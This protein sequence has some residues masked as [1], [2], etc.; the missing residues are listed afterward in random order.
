MGT[1]RTI[2]GVFADEKRAL[3]A[4]SALKETAWSVRRVHSPIPSR[5]IAEALSVKPSRVGIFTLIGGIIGFFTGFALAAYTALQWNL[6]IS[7]KPV[8]ALVPFF[9]V[10]FEFTILFAVFGNVVGLIYQMKLPDYRGL[11]HHDSRTTG[12]HFGV[13]A[14]CPDSEAHMLLDFFQEKG[15][16]TRILS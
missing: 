9:I 16:E 7:G 13:V 11:K 5:R 4:L 12:G 15:A 10:G 14:V 1:D 8:V 2:L 6:G 3:A